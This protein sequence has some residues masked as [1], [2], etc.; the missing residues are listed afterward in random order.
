[1]VLMNL[2]ENT[3]KDMGGGGGKERVGQM[4]RI[5]W[6]HEYTYHV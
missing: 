1:M 4:Q 6:K 2:T 3:L 5:V